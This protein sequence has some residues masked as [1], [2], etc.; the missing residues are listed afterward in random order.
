MGFAVGSTVTS[1]IQ[2]ISDLLPLLGTEQ[3][4]D[5]IGSA[6]KNGYLYVAAAPLSIFGSLG[7]VRAGFKALIA[8]VT[9]GF[10]STKFIGAK[11]LAYA[12]FAPSG[13][14]LSQIQWDEAHNRH[15]A[16]SQFI[17]QLEKLHLRDAS[18][19]TVESH[20]RAWNLKM[21]ATSLIAIV[22]SFTPYIYF[23][24]R[25]SNE[26]RLLRWI[27]P[28][29]RTLGSLITANMI[30]IVI[31]TRTLQIVKYHLVYMTVGDAVRNAKIVLPKWWNSQCPSEEA[32]HHLERHLAG[33]DSSLATDAVIKKRGVESRRKCKD[34][35]TVRRASDHPINEVDLE[36][37]RDGEI[38]SSEPRRENELPPEPPH[39]NDIVEV[40]IGQDHVPEQF[41]PRLDRYIPG[42]D[43]NSKRRDSEKRLDL[44]PV[45]DALVTAKAVHFPRATKLRFRFVL[46]AAQILIVGGLLLSLVGYVGCFSL[47]QGSQTSV[48][49]LI[50]LACE[51]ALSLL[52]VFLWSWN[53]EW[54]EATSMTVSVG[55]SGFTPLLTCSTPTEEIEKERRISLLRASEFLNL[56]TS[57]VGIVKPFDVTGAVYYTLAG[58]AN[59]GK[60][61]YITVFDYMENFTRVLIRRPDSPDK[62]ELRVAK[63]NDDHTSATIGEKI[64]EEESDNF[65]TADLDLFGK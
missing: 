16:E 32:L 49:P 37:G 11:K 38:P 36:S 6:L 64:S 60:T 17:D 33:K 7:I 47:V 9:A 26:P 5:H 18:K 3:C 21:F 30:Q 41:E 48:G 39:V 29:A 58:S 45:Q 15:K 27:F 43:T 50:W 54:D 35:F 24:E 42:K 52:R 57:C 46:L 1:G 25:S 51:V 4:E 14:A 13:T 53:P 55:L 61:L 10:G 28:I 65:I 59:K 34:L 40:P 8:S 20:T 23:V 31:Q 22:F 19:L 56:A 63:L 44:K 62:V 2:D 12:G